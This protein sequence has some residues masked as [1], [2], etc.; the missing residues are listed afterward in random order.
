MN[1]WTLIY[2]GFDPR[3]EPLR[4]A[5]CTLGNGYFATRGAAPESRGRRD[6]LPGHLPGRRLQPARDRDRRARDR[7]RRPRQPAQLAPARVPHRRRRAGS[8]RRASRCSTTAGARPAARRAD[9][10]RAS[11]A[12]T[13]GRE[14]RVDGAAPGAH[15]RPAPGGHRDRPSPPRTGRAASSSAA[16]STAR[17]VNAGVER[18]REPEQPAPG[19]RRDRG[20]STTTTSCLKVRTTP[21][22][23][24]RSRRRRA[25]AC[26]RDRDGRSASSGATA[27]SRASSRS[28]FAVELS[29]GRAGRRSRR[30]WRSTPRATTRSPSA[31]WR[32]ATRSARAA[33][34][35][36]RCSPPT[37]R[38]GSTSGS[39]STSSSS[40]SDGPQRRHAAMILHLHIF[41]LLQTTS[42]HTIDLDVGV[43]ARGWHG[44]AYR[45][46]IFWDELFIFPLLNFRMPEITRALLMYRYR[47]LDEAR[48]GGAR[49]RLPGR[50]VPVAERQQRPRGKPGRAPEPALGR[51]MPDNTLPAA[52]RQRGHRLQRLA[53]LPGHRATA[54]SCTSYGAEMFLEIARFWA[55]LATYNDELDRYE[56]LGVV[57]PDEYHDAYPGPRQRRA[58]TTTPTP[59]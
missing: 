51:W 6:P 15:G 39:A 14:T 16:R 5:L 18:Y 42:P 23:A 46:H 45:G 4:E 19:T 59:T 37:S 17:V 38:P 36:R 49:R 34:L 48:A 27:R 58:W 13:S 57:G 53:V 55:S 30:S 56:I 3:E 8:G 40:S 31:G 7:E 26:L 1:S 11:S 9:A 21:V 29:R 33:R 28:D 12:T 50:D 10:G 41:H 22:A 54:S 43:P 32:R 2:D 44:E 47:R 24:A 25:P 35:R 20:A 52:A